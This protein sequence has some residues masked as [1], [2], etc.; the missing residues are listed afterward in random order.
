M[1]LSH[2]EGKHSSS[3]NVHGSAIFW[4]FI[5][6]KS[7]Q[8][9][10]GFEVIEVDMKN[11]VC[12]FSHPGLVGMV[13]LGGKYCSCC[14]KD[15]I[16]ALWNCFLYSQQA[17]IGCVCMHAHGKDLLLIQLY[18]GHGDMWSG[19]GAFTC[20]GLLVLF[21]FLLQWRLAWL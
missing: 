19:S 21:Y 15:R 9:A 4:C 3:P 16:R 7:P 12:L 18:S 2:G 20:C 17:V 8:G 5:S 13:G 1:W 11:L 14:F 6:Y 10:A